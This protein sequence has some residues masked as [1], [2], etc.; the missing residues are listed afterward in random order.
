MYRLIFVFLPFIGL[1]QKVDTISIENNV[2]YVMDSIAAVNIINKAKKGETYDRM[3]K[4]VD[5]L[6]TNISSQK[7]ISDK[8]QMLLQDQLTYLR[9]E[10]I[11]E[12]AKNRQLMRANE[13]FEEDKNRLKSQ[14]NA[15]AAIGIVLL[16]VL[17]SN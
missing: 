8:M 14:R 10:L 9:S 12:S 11:S 4:E 16:T 15:F 3:N 13:T 5:K 17:I 2:M 1:S 6:V 7:I